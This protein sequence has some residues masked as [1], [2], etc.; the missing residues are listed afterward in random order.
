MA[1]GERISV[2]NRETASRAVH[3]QIETVQ[4]AFGGAGTLLP[5][6]E[7]DFIRAYSERNGGGPRS[8]GVPSVKVFPVQTSSDFSEAAPVVYLRDVSAA[9]LAGVIGH[10]GDGRVAFQP[11]QLMRANGGFLVV[12]AWRLAAAPGGW[13]VLSAAL[14]AGEVKPVTAPGFIVDA[15]PIKL[16]VR[17]VLLADAQSLEKLSALDAGVTKY[18]PF[19]ARF[20]GSALCRDADAGAIG[21][22][23]AAVAKDNSFRPIAESA[24]AV[25]YSDA[26]SRAAKPD[27]VSLDLM[28]LKTLLSE[29]DRIAAAGSSGVIRRADVE[30]AART[31]QKSS[32]P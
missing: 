4:S 16:D 25:I 32:A 14:E 22:S 13:A 7:A 15:E 23:A 1:Q 8:T 5:A 12:E 10:D 17:V 20:N 9:H 21:S 24:V 19:V 26:C 3:L 11:G 2:L 6:I 28:A 27:S 18:F 29:A 31:L 30:E